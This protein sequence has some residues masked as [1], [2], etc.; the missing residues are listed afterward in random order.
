MK[1]PFLT[2]V[3]L[4]LAI[5]LTG[6]FAGA[7]PYGKPAPPV[8]HWAAIPEVPEVEYAPNLARDLF[9][10]RGRF[11]NF[12]DGA[13]FRGTKV[14]GPWVPVPELPPVFYNIGAPYFHAPP[15]WAKGRKTGWGGAPMPPGQ[16]KKLDR[17][18]GPPGKMKPKKW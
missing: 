7:Q 8:P 5:F 12:Q 18:Y 14:T 1:N 11:Y 3:A 4:G 10:Y 6:G 17:G 16:M 13:W 15:G 9:R 2:I